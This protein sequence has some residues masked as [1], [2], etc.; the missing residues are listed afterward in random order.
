MPEAL[1]GNKASACCGLRM[2]R[3]NSRR[4]NKRASGVSLQECVAIEEKWKKWIWVSIKRLAVP[5]FSSIFVPLHLA[6]LS[7]YTSTPFSNLG[8]LISHVHSELSSNEKLC[9]TQSFFF[10]SGAVP[11]K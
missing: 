2:Q 4:R 6:I 1:A 10:P 3:R 5:V 7:A 11:V 8:A 9:C